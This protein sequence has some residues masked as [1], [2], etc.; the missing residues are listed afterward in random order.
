MQGRCVLILATEPHSA[1]QVWA[2]APLAVSTLGE[3]LKGL[4]REEQVQWLS[5]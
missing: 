5:R 4:L 2:K 1:G 3:L